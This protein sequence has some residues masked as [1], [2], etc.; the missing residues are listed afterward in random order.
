MPKVELYSPKTGGRQRGTPNCVTADVRQAIAIFAEENVHKLQEW[1]DRIAEGDPAKAA[2]LYVRL[3][4]YH[5]PKLARSEIAVHA[6]NSTTPR[7]LRDLSIAELDA[8]ASGTAD[9]ARVRAMLGLPAPAVA[10][11]DIDEAE[12]SQG[13]AAPKALR[14]TRTSVRSRSFGSGSLIRYYVTGAGL[15][16]TVVNTQISEGHREVKH[17]AHG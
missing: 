14:S 5:V 3:L 4:E 8:I 10:P 17:F 7:S 12:E 11:G 6:V 15:A 2:D 13:I 1:L 16:G 9:D